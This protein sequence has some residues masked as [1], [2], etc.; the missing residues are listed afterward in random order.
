[1]YRPRSNRKT[2]PKEG[3][4]SRLT[5]PLTGLELEKSTLP[6]AVMNTAPSARAPLAARTA[7][8]KTAT[9]NPFIR[10]LPL[11][12]LV[13]PGDRR[14]KAGQPRATPEVRRL[15]CPNQGPP[16]AGG[17]SGSTKRFKGREKRCLT[18]PVRSLSNRLR[19]ADWRRD[20]GAWPRTGRTGAGGRRPKSR[21]TQQS[22]A[23]AGF[24]PRAGCSS[25]WTARQAP[26]ILETAT[27]RPPR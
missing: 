14:Q 5:G 13:E 25:P 21:L 1:M 24:E 27:S 19:H 8:Q 6:P 2:F 4:I 26:R 10:S 22:Q 15:G 3:T 11:S 18:L 17:G 12:P 16:A 23:F 7:T 20:G 9:A